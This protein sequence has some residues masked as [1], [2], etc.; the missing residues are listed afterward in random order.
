MLR[1]ENRIITNF[2]GGYNQCVAIYLS[3]ALVVIGFF[4][5]TAARIVLTLYALEL[6]A[7]AAV[8]GALGGV[9][10]IFPVLL[11]WPVGISADKRGP[12]P[13]LFAGGISA[14]VALL[15]PYFVR[16]IPAF[17]AAAA[18]SGLSLAFFHVTLQNLVGVLSKPED[19]PRNFSNFSLAGAVSNFLGSLAAGFAI[20]LAGHAVACVFIAAVS[21]TGLVL[22]IVCGQVLPDAPPPAPAKLE[23][24]V[25][26]A[27]GA[28]ADKRADKRAMWGTLAASGLVQLGTDIFQFFLPIY[29]HSIGLSASAIGASVAAFSGASFVVRLFLAAMVRRWKAEALLAG[30]FYIGAAGCAMIPWIRDAFLLCVASTLFGLGMGIGTPLTVMLMFSRS[31]Q[32]RSGRALGLRLTSNNIVRLTGPMAFG[33]AAVVLGLLSVF[34]INALLMGVGGVYAQ[35]R[36]RR[37]T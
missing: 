8:V 6:G 37:R 9:F 14:T 29:G 18:L 25:S 24:K 21:L 5:I 11:S 12:R 34:W 23:P 22:L 26:A 33:V 35:W 32:G 19:R 4:G 17:F 7:S 31:A 15:L 27:G 36:A 13:L 1:G 2:R 28:Q 30:A 16:E 20:D 3:L 10:Y